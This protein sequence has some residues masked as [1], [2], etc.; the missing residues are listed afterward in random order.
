ML[1]HYVFSSYMVVYNHKLQIQYKLLHEKLKKHKSYFIVIHGV[2][3]GQRQ[4]EFCQRQVEIN[5]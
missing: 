2:I 5:L 4:V 3:H 1:A